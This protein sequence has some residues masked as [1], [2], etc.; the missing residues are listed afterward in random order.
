MTVSDA[1]INR[2]NLRRH[3]LSAEVIILDSLKL[4]PIGKL[5]DIHQEGLLL[6]GRSLLMGSSHQLSLVLPNNINH[7]T[8]LDL[9]IE[10]LWC[11][12]SL[13]D[14]ALYWVGCTIIDKSKNASAS[15]QSLINITSQ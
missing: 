13:N 11:Q 2:R 1:L 7:Q 12:P 14:D 8:Y 15:I 4:E 6:L 9:G 3:K 5:V 10:C